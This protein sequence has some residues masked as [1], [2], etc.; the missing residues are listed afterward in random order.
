MLQSALDQVDADM[1]AQAVSVARA[2][3]GEDADGGGGQQ[4]ISEGKEEL[5]QRRKAADRFLN[6]L[7][8]LQGPD[9]IRPR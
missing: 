9:C 6:D 8:P 1:P 3:L 2:F 7:L 4:D 5:W